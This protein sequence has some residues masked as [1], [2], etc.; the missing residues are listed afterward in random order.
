[1]RFDAHYGREK[2]YEP[3]SFGGPTQSGEPLYGSL[4]GGSSGT[5]GWNHREG[6]NF[7][8]AGALYRLMPEDAKARLVDNI[9][10]GLSQVS[11]EDIIER[12]ITSFRLADPDYGARVETAVKARPS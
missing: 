11:R 10:S 2:N 1:M 8:Q 7:S 12:S 9:A 6:D 4:A 3:N 5:Y